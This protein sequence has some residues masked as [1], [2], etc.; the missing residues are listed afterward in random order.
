LYASPVRLV[1]IAEPPA[2]AAAERSHVRDLRVRN[3]GY[4]I[5][6]VKHRMVGRHVDDRPIREYALQ[7][8]FESDPVVRAEEAVREQEAAAQQVFAQ[9][10][11]LRV[12]ELPI[13]GEPDD[14]ERPIEDVVAV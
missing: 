1:T 9:L 13:A 12:R 14:Q 7:A 3:L 5:D 11:H 10:G 2:T 8:S 4:V 6:D